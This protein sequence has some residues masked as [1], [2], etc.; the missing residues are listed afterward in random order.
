MNDTVE[1]LCK[2]PGISAPNTSWSIQKS[3][4]TIRL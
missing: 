4:Q 2:V 3:L 1:R